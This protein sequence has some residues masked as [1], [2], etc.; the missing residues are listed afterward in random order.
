M[1]FLC[2]S[3]KSRFQDSIN[4]LFFPSLVGRMSIDFSIFE[5]IISREIKNR[6]HSDAIFVRIDHCFW[7]G[8]S[9]KNFSKC[10]KKNSINCKGRGVSSGTVILHLHVLRWEFS[11]IQF[12]V[13]KIKN[14]RFCLMYM[15]V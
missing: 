4:H 5:L 1:T 8:R 11:N 15:F 10:K 7:Y 2:I 6:G 12:I 13:L 3:I 9:R 14:L